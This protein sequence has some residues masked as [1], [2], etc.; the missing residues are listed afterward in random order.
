MKI[1]LKV[2][3]D[4]ACLPKDGF[5]LWL[6]FQN[7]ALTADKLHRFGIIGP[8]WCVMCKQNNE[9]IYNLFLKCPFVQTCW[10]WIKSRLKWTTPLQNSLQELLCSWPTHMVHGVYSKLWNICPS[11][12][13]WELWKERKLHIFQDKEWNIDK[14]LLKLEVSITETMNAYLRKT[15]HEEGSFSYWDG[16]MKK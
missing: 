14:F 12:V 11:P 6:A 4:I 2:C 1:P 5:F 13:V 3:W 9:D 7:R 16:L 15:S 10:E 8:N